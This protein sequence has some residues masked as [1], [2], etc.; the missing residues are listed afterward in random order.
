MDTLLFRKADRFFGSFSTCTVQ[1]SLDNADTYL[2]LTQGC[3]PLLINSTTIALVCTVLASDHAAFPASVQQGRALDRAFVA[4]NSTGTHCHT[5][6]KY[7]GASEIRTASII[8]TRC[9]GPMM[10]AIEGLHC[11]HSLP[12]SCLHNYANHQ[13]QLATK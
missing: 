7:T 12:R 5:Y 9:G 8:Q 10:S 3:Q 2:P 6:R 4:L 13:Q 11:S 1:N